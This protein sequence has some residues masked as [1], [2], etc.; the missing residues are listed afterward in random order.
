[1]IRVPVCP[2]C[3]VHGP[4][5]V[6]RLP[7]VFLNPEPGKKTPGGAGTQTWDTDTHGPGTFLP[8]S[9]LRPSRPTVLCDPTVPYVIDAF[10]L[11]GWAWPDTRSHSH[12]TGTIV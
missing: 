6:S 1:M 7:S 3:P 12:T 2:V 8:L 5:R 9:Y 4:V 10:T 11:S